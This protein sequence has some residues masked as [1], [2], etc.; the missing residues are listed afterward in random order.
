MAHE[1]TGRPGVKAADK[2]GDELVPGDVDPHDLGR[3][4]IVTNRDKG[5]ARSCPGQV[6]GEKSTGQKEDKDNLIKSLVTA[7]IETEEDRGPDINAMHAAGKGPPVFDKIYDQELGGHRGH[8]E[9]E[10]LDPEGRESDDDPHRPGQ[11]SPAQYTDDK[12]YSG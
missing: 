12:R 3:K 4:I 5:P 6:L 8:D 1:R 7:E 11:E 2:K 10:T 9:I